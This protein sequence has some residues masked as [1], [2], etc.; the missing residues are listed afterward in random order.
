M[1]I[2]KPPCR[3]PQ[4]GLSLP[5]TV[6]I[7]DSGRNPGNSGTP[8]PYRIY[9]TA[10][11]RPLVARAETLMQTRAAISALR[12][13]TAVSDTRFV[14]TNTGRPKTRKGTIYLSIDRVDAVLQYPNAVFLITRRLPKRSDKASVTIAN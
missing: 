11:N 1:E 8:A 3:T 4:Q 2:L 13:V 14:K 12:E 10:D 9:H 7:F 5:L 6:K